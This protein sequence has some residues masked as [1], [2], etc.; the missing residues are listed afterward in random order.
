MALLLFQLLLTAYWACFYE[1]L[2]I[3]GLFSSDLPP[4]CLFDFLAD[5]SFCWIVLPKH[6]GL[7]LRFNS[8]FWLVF[9][10]YLFVFAK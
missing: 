10:I 3:L 2:L 4:Y 9:Q 1:N 8:R 5:F 6:V 7:V